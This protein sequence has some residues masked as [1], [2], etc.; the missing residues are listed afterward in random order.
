MT[1]ATENIR[2][3]GICYRDIRWLRT[4]RHR[5]GAQHALNEIRII[6][7]GDRDDIGFSTQRERDVLLDLARARSGSEGWSSFRGIR[8]YCGECEHMAVDCECA[9][10]SSG[11]LYV[12]RCEQCGSPCSDGED[13]CEP[14][15]E[16]EP[17]P[18]IQRRALRKGG[19]KT[20]FAPYYVGIEVETHSTPDHYCIDR[21]RADPD[22]W[23]GIVSDGSIRGIEILTQPL[24]GQALV[25]AIRDIAR[26]PVSFDGASVGAH[27][28]L[29]MHVDCSESSAATRAE[30]VR[31]YRHV[32]PAL[33]S[34]PE[35]ADRAASGYCHE[36]P[37]TVQEYA[38][39]LAS[40]PDTHPMSA[41]DRYMGLNVTA[42]AEHSTIEL[43]LW[44]WPAG[45]SRWDVA[46]RERFIM[47]CMRVTQAIRTAGRWL[48]SSGMRGSHP[49][50]A[51]TP[52]QAL[53][54]ACSLIPE[55]T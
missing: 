41:P 24:R 19:V 44:G 20:P 36:V 34:W 52:W 27:C 25:D 3:A 53:D 13:C 28:G 2:A 45:C 54:M 31:I 5:A 33:R 23:L 15:E 7:M 26:L 16:E 12:H 17:S 39:R 38:D 37:S 29:H 43:R 8:T 32:E 14:E 11:D 50:Y 46:R 9:V 49:I 40:Y 55:V 10:S 4:M 18:W 35:L 51:L 47:R 30:M 42:F 21:I 22:R 48:A 6:A 1:Q